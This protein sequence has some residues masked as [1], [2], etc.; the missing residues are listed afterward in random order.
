MFS[1]TKKFMFIILSAII[2]PQNFIYAGKFEFKEAGNLYILDDSKITFSISDR[3]IPIQNKCMAAYIIYEYFEMRIN[4][5]IKS[6]SVQDL[7]HTQEMSDILHIVHQ[8]DQSV[9]LSTRSAV[10]IVDHLKNSIEC[11]KDACSKYFQALSKCD[12]LM[13]NIANKKSMELLDLFKSY[14]KTKFKYYNLSTE[15]AEILLEAY[16]AR[17]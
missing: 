17:H 1:K 8:A 15:R 10:N 16:T 7:L 14:Y 12:E 4:K 5:E 3:I 13:Q 6:R 9:L 2:I 11:Y